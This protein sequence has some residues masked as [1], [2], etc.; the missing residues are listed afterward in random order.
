MLGA[1]KNCDYAPPKLLERDEIV[2]RPG[3]WTDM[4]RARRAV[5][6]RK[7]DEDG[8]HEPKKAEEVRKEAQEMSKQDETD[9]KQ[10]QAGVHEPKKTEQV[11]KEAQ[12]MSM[13][14]QHSVEPD[15]EA[16][17]RTEDGQLEPIRPVAQFDGLR[18]IQA[19]GNP[20]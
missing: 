10:G 11:H 12:E 20:G 8:V 16:D 19:F 13:E 15:E 2:D 9:R 3:I 7:Q 4:E 14:R 17:R 5:Q 18:A 1:V 6:D